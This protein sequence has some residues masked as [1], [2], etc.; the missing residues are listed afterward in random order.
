MKPQRAAAIGAILLAGAALA[1]YVLRSG[2]P[3]AEVEATS[4]EAGAHDAG[5]EHDTGREHDAGRAGDED[6]EHEQADDHDGRIELSASAAARAG[7][8]V[9]AAGPARLETRLRLNGR[10]APNEDR[11]AHVLP[12]F[13]GIVREVRKHVGDAVGKGE[14]M[15]VVQSNQSLQSYE[16]RSEI[17]GTVIQKHVTPG[18]F[19]AEGD[20]LYTVA[21]LDTVWVD[22]DV[23]RQDFARVAVGQPVVLDAGEGLPKAEGRIAY[24]SPF[25]SASTQTMLARVVL[26]NPDRSW[27]PGFFV[28]GEVV[29]E[30]AEVPLAVRARAI[31]ALGDRSVVFVQEGDAY[32]AAPVEIGRRDDEWV[33]VVSG[34]EP[35]RR[36]VAR[37]SFVLKAELG[38]SAASH[39]H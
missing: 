2:R 11:L 30:R 36:Y 4:P 31:Q 27:R 17:A 24:I 29:V 13:A 25:G 9:E 5:H 37:G 1:V 18:E 32:E 22:L 12:R 20:H 38:K 21:D 14:I 33:E 3:T 35:G 16:L 19:A 7:I 39:D 8:E 15:A 34:L 10:I 28:T 26:P 23:Y 6:H